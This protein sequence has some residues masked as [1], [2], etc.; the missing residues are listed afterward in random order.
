VVT[1]LSEPHA[2]F[3]QVV[4]VISLR[5]QPAMETRC[6]LCDEAMPDGGYVRATTAM[7]NGSAAPDTMCA[8]CAALPAE[9]RK[10]LR[11]QAMTRMLRNGD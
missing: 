8:H 1:V 6:T 10:P 5:R 4:A 3:I 9:E 2:V 7:A 11:D